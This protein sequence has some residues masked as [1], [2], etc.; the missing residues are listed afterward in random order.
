MDILFPGAFFES[1]VSFLTQKVAKSLHLFGS[2]VWYTKRGRK[3]KLQ[4]D[5]FDGIFSIKFSETN[6]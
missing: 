4:I 5:S 2:F 1:T 6:N 3:K